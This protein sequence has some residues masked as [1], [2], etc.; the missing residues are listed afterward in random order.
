MDN[1]Q[2]MGQELHRR[3]DEFGPIL[4]F[5]DGNKRYL[6]FGTADEQSCQLNQAPLQLQ[7]EYSRCMAAVLIQTEQF[8]Q[9][10]N[11]TLLGVGGG[12][13]A[14]CLHHVLSEAVITA[15]DIRAAVIQ[16]ANQ[17]FH[18]PRGPRLKTQ[19]AD[20]YEFL[21]SAEPNKANLI[22]T[23]LYQASGLD[24]LVLQR[25]FLDSCRTHLQHDGWLVLNLWKEHREQ[26]NCLDELKARFN[27]VLQTTTS[28]GNWIIWASNSV[29][30]SKKTA[31][32]RCREYSPAMQFNLWTL[33]KG[34]Y[35]HTSL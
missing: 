34:F 10:R 30:C 24:P 26:T 28:D 4:V 25:E 8:A 31:Q 29:P 20:A 27:W 22:I 3:F 9:I 7:H 13:I 21:K 32:Q 33:V 18:L 2:H 35:R 23:D 12:T 17:Y 5:D 1:L 16:V 14:S 19:V 6:S 11:V 15:V